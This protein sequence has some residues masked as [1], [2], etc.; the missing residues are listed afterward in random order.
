M[1]DVPLVLSSLKS[2]I[3]RS[4]MPLEMSNKNQPEM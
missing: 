2:S 3:D 4:G 1:P